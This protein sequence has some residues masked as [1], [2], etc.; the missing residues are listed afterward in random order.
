MPPKR[1]DVPFSMAFTNPYAAQ[2]HALIP[3]RTHFNA[4]LGEDRWDCYTNDIFDTPPHFERGH[5]DTDSVAPDFFNGFS[6]AQYLIAR[7]RGGIAI[8]PVLT[9][10]FFD[11]DKWIAF[12][13]HESEKEIVFYFDTPYDL[14][15]AVAG[16]GH[17][18][19]SRDEYE[20]A[21]EKIAELID[22]ITDKNWPGMH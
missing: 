12:L 13:S 1:G 4:R 22:E 6:M 15:D 11:P 9:G 7:K 14:Y 18:V 10:L 21:N 3:I 8:N 16:T 19:V 20:A 2:L 5:E 17:F